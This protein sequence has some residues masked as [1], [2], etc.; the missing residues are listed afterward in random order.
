[1]STLFP[2]ERDMPKTK[3]PIMKTALLVFL[4]IA[5]FSRE[6]AALD[7]L[8][9]AGVS[10]SYPRGEEEIARRLQ[11][12]APGIMAFLKSYGLPVKTPLHVI[13][14]EEL[15]QPE[16]ITD[17]VPHRE[18]RIPLRAP[19][20]LEEGFLE[21]DP[22]LYFLFKGMCLQGIYSVRQGLPAQAHRVFG[23]AASPNLILPPWFTDGVCRILYASWS[24][25]PLTD[26]YSQALFSTSVPRDFS[27][28]SNHPGSW[29]GYFA[30][31]IYGIPFMSWVNSRFG[32]DRIREFI[33]IHGGGIVPIEIELKARKAFGQS[34]SELWEDFVRETPVGRGDAQGMLIE[35]YCPDPFLYWNTSGMYPGRKSVELRSR[36]GFVDPK[37]TLWLSGYTAGG[38]SRI[39]GY[40]NGMVMDGGERHIWD[41]SSG[42][43]GVTREGSRPCLAFFDLTG[44]GPLARVQVVRKIPAPPGVI[45]LSG[46]VMSGTG[47]V[48]VAGNSG[49]NWDIWVYDKG[50]RR[51]TSGPGIEMDPWWEGTQPVFSSD[52]TGLFQ[53]HD[54]HLTPMTHASMGALLPRSGAFLSLAPSGWKV[55]HYPVGPASSSGPEPAAALAYDPGENQGQEETGLEAQPYSPLESIL[56]DFIA[57]DFYAG[58]SDVQAGLV[59]WGRDVSGEYSLRGGARY[60]FSLDYIS[61]QASSQIKGMGLSYSRYPLSYDPENQPSTEESRSE[62]GISYRYSG[63]PWAVL[64]LNRQY[65]EPLEDQG[66]R[67]DDL[68]GEAQF[69]KQIGPLTPS[70][71][72]E[73]H[74]GGMSSAFGSLSFVCG[75]DIVFQ[76]TV[77]GGKSWGETSPGHGTFRVGGDVG[78]G[79]FTR[80][81]SRLFPLRGF[82]P[83]ILEASQ[84]F[85]LSSELS[86]PLANLQMGHNTLPVFFHRLSLGTFVD[87]GACSEKITRDELMAGVGFELLTS[88]EVAWSHFSLF[89]I[90]AAWPAVQPEGLHERGPVL[91][92]QIGR[93]L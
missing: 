60:S 19:G 32:W 43:V 53:I 17:L 67:G 1:L 47:S 56:P 37:G 80:R 91:V 71:T 30:S 18:I 28:V 13:L 76:S 22:W 52:M 85:I 62:V 92:F 87:A 15:D 2:K 4:F 74:S 61:L 23:E 14:D 66:S 57:P 39:V 54:A 48:A 83:N 51:V 68:W 9:N 5:S 89:K 79:Y 42:H 36:Y 88:M 69:R 64:S 86:F 70:I 31:R 73:A 81:A 45:Q 63:L 55:D 27:L 24:G 21:K 10:I 77:Q 20:V 90:G 84:A 8:K 40:G 34:W 41:P 58:P 25:T 7:V 75:R 29:P 35:G 82:S 46:P 93:P 50:W 65:Y 12:K 6:G 44:Q 72:V 3:V 49:G 33:A 11:Q 78:E 16:V 38:V 59:T 26:R